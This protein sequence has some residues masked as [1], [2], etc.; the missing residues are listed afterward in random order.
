MHSRRLA[1]SPVKEDS[2]LRVCFD[3]SQEDPDELIRIAR[4][5]WR[6]VYPPPRTRNRPRV[7]KGVKRKAVEEGT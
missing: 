6:R 7:D 3:A 1:M 2:F 4:K 5:I